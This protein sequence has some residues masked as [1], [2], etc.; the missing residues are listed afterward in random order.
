M[1]YK[2]TIMI[3]NLS[4]SESRNEIIA[5]SVRDACYKSLMAA[6]PGSRVMGIVRHGR[7]A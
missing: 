6:S 5:K 1:K 4:G 3:R 2:Y 7:C